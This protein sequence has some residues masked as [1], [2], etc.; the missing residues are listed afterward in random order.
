MI[1]FGHTWARLHLYLTSES[2]RANLYSSL[3][4]INASLPRWKCH[5]NAMCTFLL[6]RFRVSF[7]SNWNITL[8]EMLKMFLHFIYIR[9]NVRDANALFPFLLKLCKY[10]F[11]ISLQWYILLFFYLCFN[12]YEERMRNCIGTCI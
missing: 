4:L 9:W 12:S 5:W 7:N 6:W 3:H 8:N 11:V 2:S 1:K 10:N